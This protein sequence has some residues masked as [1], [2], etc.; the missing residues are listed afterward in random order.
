VLVNAINAASWNG[1]GAES[2]SLTWIF[3]IAEAMF[4]AAQAQPI[5]QPI[6]PDSSLV[7]SSHEVAIYTLFASQQIEPYQLHCMF[8][9]ERM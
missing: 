2:V 5:L 1:A 9:I 8:L 7:N 3:L 6:N 4:A